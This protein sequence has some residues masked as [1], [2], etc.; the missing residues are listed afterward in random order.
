M[1]CFAVNLF[2]ALF[3]PRRREVTYVWRMWREWA[4]VLHSYIWDWHT[5]IYLQL[6][7]IYI[8]RSKT[9]RL[10]WILDNGEHMSP[11]NSNTVGVA[12][13]GNR[14]RRRRLFHTQNTYHQHS[15]RIYENWPTIWN[16]S[17]AH[18]ADGGTHTLT[19]TNSL[20]LTSDEPRTCVEA[21]WTG[22][23]EM[24]NE[25]VLMFLFQNV[26]HQFWYVC[27]HWGNIFRMARTLVCVEPKHIS[28]VSLGLN[29]NRSTIVV[30]SPYR[31]AIDVS[32]AEMALFCFDVL[33][34]MM[35][36]WPTVQRKKRKD[37][38]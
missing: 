24:I 28:F 11:I 6:I 9:W 35:Y 4:N 36:N 17:I 16:E 33:D 3:S 31:W 12:A 21:Q 29:S 32:C 25:V 18:D 5:H 2:S 8:F 19:H 20:S 30:D 27:A 7:W 37:K 14:C 26:A 1:L 13:A 10:K 23:R 38:K 34:R 15:Y 22:T